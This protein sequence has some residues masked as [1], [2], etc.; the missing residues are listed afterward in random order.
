VGR[1]K[2]KQK[3]NTMWFDNKPFHDEQNENILVNIFRND[4]NHQHAQGRFEGTN[5][6]GQ[7]TRKWIEYENGEHEPVD[8]FGDLRKKKRGNGRPDWWVVDKPKDW[9]PQKSKTTSA[10]TIDNRGMLASSAFGSLS[11]HAQETRQ[12][13]FRPNQPLTDARTEHERRKEAQ[14]GKSVQDEKEQDGTPRGLPPLV[15]GS[16]GK[17]VQSKSGPLSGDNEA[18][19]NARKA[20]KGTSPE[21]LSN[22]KIE[23]DARIRELEQLK[24]TATGKERTKILN[25]LKSLRG[26]RKLLT[27][28]KDKKKE[29]LKLPSIGR[30]LFRGPLFFMIDPHQWIQDACDEDGNCNT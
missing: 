30:G 14:W 20:A 25:E 26:S 27:R 19:S 18:I 15:I 11:L 22:A 4:P 12:A 21:S 3:E 13:S 16:R 10:P 6:S 24:E 7:R 28:E 5:P 8:P 9:Q 23:I 29:G 17:G 2:P 1:A